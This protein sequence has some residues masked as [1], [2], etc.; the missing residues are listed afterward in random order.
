MY[1]NFLILSLYTFVRKFYYSSVSHLCS[2]DQRIDEQIYTDGHAC[3]SHL[4]ERD[5]DDETMSAMII[6]CFRFYFSGYKMLR[7]A[8]HAA[9]GRVADRNTCSTGDRANARR[10]EGHTGPSGR[11][12]ESAGDRRSH[13]AASG[14]PSSSSTSFSSQQSQE[15]TQ[16]SGLA[17]RR[18]LK[19][20]I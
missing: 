17:L 14:A 20:K 10:A 2:I 6:V 12:P 11:P 13:A 18:G 5:V 16:F 1:Y 3:S 4:S 15:E 8:L 7:V 19:K 9:A